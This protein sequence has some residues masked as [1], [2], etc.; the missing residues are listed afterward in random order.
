MTHLTDYSGHF[1]CILKAFLVTI[2]IAIDFFNTAFAEPLT[3]GIFPRRDAAVTAKL[4]RPFAKYLEKELQRPVKL[5]LSPNFNVFLKRLEERRYDLVH[6]NQFEYIN[7]HKR[8]NYDV[9]AQNEEFGEKTIRGAIYVRRDSGIEHLEQL[10]GKNILFGG[11]KRAMMSY[12]VPTYL[13][14]GAGLKKSDYKESF[15]SNPPNAVLATF[16]RQADAGG[17]GEIVSRLPLVTNKIDIKD[18][19]LIAVSEALP[20]LPWAV[21]LEMDSNLRTRIT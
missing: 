19:N 10:K 4:F 6:F 12:I 1:R 20:H 2:L 18:L 3:V 16:Q 7:A 21:K 17:A 9:I 8:L 5:E 13:L 11:G 15:A 14:R